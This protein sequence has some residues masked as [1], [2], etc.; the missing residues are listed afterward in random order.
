[1]HII[2]TITAT[3]DRYLSIAPEKARRSMVEAYHWSKGAE[4]LNR[5]LSSPIL[6]QDRDALWATAAMLGIASVTSI[7]ASNPWEAWPLKPYDPNDLDWLDMSQGK[8]AIWKVTDPLRPDSIFHKMAPEYRA[9][10][11]PTRP[12]EFEE[13]PEEL[14]RLCNLSGVA[15]LQHNPYYLPVSMLVS[16][17]GVQCTQASMTRF[18]QFMGQMQP[19]FRNLLHKKDPRALMILANWY[20]PMRQSLWWIARRAQLECQAICLYL[21]KHHPNNRDL[22]K[23][24]PRLD[25][26]G[27]TMI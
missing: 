27:L 24:L 17:R 21:E 16:L 26:Q 10:N 1:M 19:A 2:L 3:H 25:T 18:L 5:K 13:I 14:A 12:C 23:M 8:E 22:Q 7:E 11:V 15:E 9:L 4:L 20:A 6:P